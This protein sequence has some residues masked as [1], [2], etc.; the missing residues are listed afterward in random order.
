LIFVRILCQESADWI[1]WNFNEVVGYFKQSLASK[2]GSKAKEFAKQMLSLL[3]N[4]HPKYLDLSKSLR[5]DEEQVK[6]LV[7]LQSTEIQTEEI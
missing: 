3:W 7:A 6:T 1:K 4:R 2:E 5:I